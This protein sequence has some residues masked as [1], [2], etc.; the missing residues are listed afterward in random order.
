MWD[1]L[2]QILNIS[3]GRGVIIEDGEPK[4]VILSIDEYLSLKGEGGSAGVQ[5]DPA[6]QN[7]ANPGRL[8][9]NDSNNPGYAAE[10]PIPNSA[11]PVDLSSID[12]SDVNMNDGLQ[13]IDNGNGASKRD[14]SLDDLPL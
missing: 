9:G 4:Y 3:N 5:Q 7:S 12:T 6:A 10:N 14:V 13:Y 11:P 8:D 1:K 2:K